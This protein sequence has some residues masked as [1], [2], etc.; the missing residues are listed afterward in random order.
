MKII[1]V[2]QKSDEWLHVKKGKISGTQAKGLMGTPASEITTIYDLLGERLKV[3]VDNGE[4]ESPI[5]RG[6]RLEPEARML[7]EDMTGNSVKE[8]GFAE[9][10]SYANIGNSPDGFVGEDGAIEIKCPEHTNYMRYWLN[11]EKGEDGLYAAT[12]NAIIPKD[13]VW[14]VAQYFLVNEKIQWLDF[15]V[16]NPDIAMYAMHIIHVTRQQMQENIDIL[17]PKE[18][19][20]LKSVENILEGIIEF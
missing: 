6:N 15:I 9:H 5:D 12:V 18:I 11:I 3:G 1:N 16:Y 8:I 19:I 14:Q 17:L 4:Y 10:E 7:Y 2:K 13:Y 20:L